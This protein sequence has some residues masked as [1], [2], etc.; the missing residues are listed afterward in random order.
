MDDEKEPNAEILERIE[1]EREKRVK[2]RWQ[3]YAARLDPTKADPPEPGYGLDGYPLQVGRGTSS[4]AARHLPQTGKAY[5]VP[6]DAGEK[7]E[8]HDEV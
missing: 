6:A 3:I 4:G 7:G 2:L 1:A 8:G 5:E